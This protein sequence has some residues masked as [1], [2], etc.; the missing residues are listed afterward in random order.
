MTEGMLE[1]DKGKEF[2]VLPVK[3]G[4]GIRIDVA[5]QYGRMGIRQVDMLNNSKCHVGLPGGWT[6]QDLG[7][8]IWRRLIDGEGRRRAMYFL[9]DYGG[10]SFIV[11]C[12]RYEWDIRP[13]DNY[14]DETVTDAQRR[15][16]EWYG[17][18][19]DCGD[20]IA[21]TEPYKPQTMREYERVMPN[22]LGRRCEEYLQKHYPEYMDVNAYWD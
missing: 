6:V 5:K 13:F 12:R 11:F 16:D 22:V 14:E 20:E 17:V 10:G 4:K 21:R 8:G 3:T 18:I 9:A 7:R 2:A 19:T 15:F 1:M